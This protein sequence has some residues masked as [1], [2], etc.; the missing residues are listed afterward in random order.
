MVNYYHILGVPEGATLEQI[1]KGWRSQAK[2]FHP[3][4]NHHANATTQM[5]SVN[6]AFT[7]LSDPIKRTQYDA[8]PRAARTT[9]PFSSVYQQR[10]PRIYNDNT[11]TQMSKPMAQVIVAG[12]AII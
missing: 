2:R 12:G 9:K 6:E 1:R 11:Q 5:K 10:G 7:V 8:R 4:L 3:D